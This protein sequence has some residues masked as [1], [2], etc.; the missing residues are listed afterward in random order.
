MHVVDQAG[1]V[2][3]VRCS[4]PRLVLPVRVGSGPPAPTRG[5]AQARRW[6]RTGPGLYVPSSV[7]RTVEQRIVEAW[8]RLPSAVV[9]G[10][11]AARLHGA[12]YLDG[13][14]LEDEQRPVP[15][16]LPPGTSAP[17]AWPGAQVIRQPM[18]P[19]HRTSVQDV[20]VATPDRAVVDMARLTRDYYAAV[21]DVEMAYAAGIVRPEQVVAALAEAPAWGRH[22]ARQVLRDADTRSCSPPESRLRLVCRAMGWDPLVNVEVFDLE[23]QFLA[24]PDLLDVDR[25]VAVEY[26]GAEHRSAARHRRDNDRLHLLRTAG[27]EVVTIVGGGLKTPED[28]ASAAQLLRDGER[29][30]ARP[31]ERGWTLE[32]PPWHAPWVPRVERRPARR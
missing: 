15:L 19:R 7:P 12:A 3:D 4:I 23:G 11:A 22:R 25:G 27:L 5:E 24:R 8:A 1:T 28:R 26:D 14:D 30:A 32:A 20:P 29:L 18:Q 31:R 2:S 6:R 13:L 16:V 17:R 9:T 21:V 10:W